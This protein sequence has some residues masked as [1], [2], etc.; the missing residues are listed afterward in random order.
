MGFFRKKPSGAVLE[1]PQRA[2]Q[3]A[4]HRAAVHAG[5]PGRC[6]EC[7]GFGYID[8]IDMTHRFQSQHCRECNHAWE[9]TFDDEGDVLDLTD[10]AVARTP[11]TD[12]DN[13]GSI[14]R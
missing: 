10:A 11:A 12:T 3:P 1:V 7:D 9:F 2:S 14:P 13:R 6:P 8:H 5:V 4:E